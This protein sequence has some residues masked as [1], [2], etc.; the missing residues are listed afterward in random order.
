MRWKAQELQLLEQLHD[1]G[2]PLDQRA[3]SEAR[4]ACRGLEIISPEIPSENVIYTRASG[5][6]GLMVSLD[7]EN[8]SDRIIRIE[9]IRLKMPWSD[10]NFTWLPKLSSRELRERG[11]YVLPACGTYGFDF[12]VVLNHRFGRDFK[13]FPG[14]VCEGLLLGQSSSTVPDDYPDRAKI[15]M[16]LLVFAGRGE[17]FGSWVMLGLDREEKVTTR[18][19][20]GQQVQ[21]TSVMRNVQRENGVYRVRYVHK[22]DR[23]T[24]S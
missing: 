4:A 14:D 6:M 22:S 15:P 12:S 7:I 17:V 10:H 11:G 20:A 18:K 5:D 2:T 9:T 16:Q 24:A 3:L 8:V 13:L 1:G 19:P 23:R 21:P